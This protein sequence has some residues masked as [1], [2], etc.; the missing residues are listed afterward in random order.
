L[1]S[2]GL[3]SAGKT[4][5]IV[6][7]AGLGLLRSLKLLGNIAGTAATLQNI[8]A[9]VDT[10][11]VAVAG[12]AGQTEQLQK[13]LDH[14][15]AQMVTKDEINQTLER[16][17][18]RVEEEVEARFEHQA[19]SV[20]ALRTMVGQT[21]ELLQRVLDGLESLKVDNEELSGAER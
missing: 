1:P 14:T 15:A 8:A 18:G 9:R 16:V 4:T 3:I 20:E 21:D 7:G 2:K 13:R 12:L 11:Y 6:I 17:F 19:R 10:L 5:L